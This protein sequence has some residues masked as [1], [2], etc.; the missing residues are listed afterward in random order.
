VE[1]PVKTILDALGLISGDR[2]S[3]KALDQERLKVKKRAK[4]LNDIAAIQ[5]ALA[6]RIR[7][8]ERSSRQ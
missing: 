2:S 7:S 4:D 5:E 6:A 3:A 8:V 1:N